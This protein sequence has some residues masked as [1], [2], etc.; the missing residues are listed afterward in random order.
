METVINNFLRP[1]SASPTIIGKGLYG[2]NPAYFKI[3]YNGTNAQKKNI[4]N[5]ALLYE[6][7]IYNLISQ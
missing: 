3:F 2:G 4:T 5:D 7:Q 6:S 1:N